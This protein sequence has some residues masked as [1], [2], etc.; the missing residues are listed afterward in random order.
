MRILQLIFRNDF[1]ATKMLRNI[2]ITKVRHHF[3]KDFLSPIQ[4]FI[5]DGYNDMLFSNLE[6]DSSDQVVIL[7]GYI[8]VSANSINQNYASTIKIFEPIPEFC[9]I[10]R[11]RFHSFN[12]VEVIEAA[13]AIFNGSLDLGI[14]GEKTGIE[15]QGPKISVPALNFSQ[16]ISDNFQ[17]LSLLEMN[18]EGGE[19]LILPNLIETNQIKKIK[20]LLIQ[21]HR[22][23]INDEFKRNLIRQKLSDTHR[24]VFS[25][26]WVWEKWEL[27]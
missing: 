22:F 19:Y 18:I 23:S 21:F 8:G 10:L 4:Q 11:E 26:D 27:I 13:A 12:N 16:Y 3:G 2:P 1:I 9:S 17:Y 24:L 20:I 7:G 5:R 6:L 14:E 25:Y 15:V